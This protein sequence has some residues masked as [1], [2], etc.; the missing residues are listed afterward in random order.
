MNNM[1]LLL[2]I[3]LFLMTSIVAPVQAQNSAA[4]SSIASRKWLSSGGT[5]KIEQRVHD[6]GLGDIVQET[7]SF[8]G[9]SLPDVVVRHEYDE[10]RRSWLPVAASPGG[11]F[12]SGGTV[13][14]MAQSQ[15]SDTAPF[16][17]T[18]YDGFLQS[19]PAAQYKAGTQ[20]Q[21]NDRKVSVS[22]SEHVGAG[23]FSDADG[24]MYTL[25]G[26]KF[27]RTRVLDEDSCMSAEYT[28]LNGR[29]MA[30][31]TTQGMTFY[32][33]D[34]KGDIKYVIP[35]ILS[36][37][38]LSHYGDESEDIPDTDDMMRK[39]AYVYRYDSQ[40]HCIYKKLPGC[41]P[42]YY[43]YDR[44]GSCILSQDGKQRQKGV[45]AYSIPD[46]FG[47]PCISGICHNSASYSLEPLHSVSVHAEYD[48]SS[49]RTGGYA[50][51]N[52]TLVSDTL[53]YAAYYDGYSFIGH[54]GV[55]SSL[56]YA[57]VPGF[58]ADSSLGRGLQTGTATAILGG[59]SVT[60]YL[61]SAMY[62]DSRYNVAQVRATNHL[63]ST[64]ITSTSSSYTGKPLSVRI[65]NTAGP[66]MTEVC[67]T[68]AYDGADRMV[69]HTVSVTH[70]GPAASATLT[71]AY[72]AL[73]R[74]SS[75]TRPLATEQSHDI[76]YTYDLHGWTKS[77]A[78][79]G[80]CEELFYADGP[81]T[82]CYNG[83]VSSMR[84]SNSNYPYKRGYKLT[85][86]D[87]NRLIQAKYGRGDNIGGA[88]LFSENI[89][90]DAHGN[91]T[92]ITRLGKNASSSH[93]PMDKLTLS[94]DGN[95][96]AGVT[97]AAAD[98]DATGTFEYKRAKGSQYMYDEN[99]SLI[100]D[101]SRGIAYITYDV[102]GNPQRICFTNGNE[103]RYLYSATGEKLRTVYYV[104]KPN[105]T[106]TFGVEPGEPG[107][108]DI[109]YTSQMNYLLGGRLLVR[110]GMADR[111][112]FDGG[113]AKASILNPM[114]YNFTMHY[115]NTDHLGSNRE[116]VAA[117]GTVEQITNYYPFGAPFAD[118]ETV[119]DA[120]LQPYKYNGKELDRMHG[121][122]TYDYGARQYNPILTRWDRMDPLCEKYYDVSPYAYC[123]NNP[124]NAIDPDG[125]KVRYIN[126]ASNDFKRK[127]ANAIN[128]LNKH[129]V[130]YIF[131]KL[132]RLKTTI[133]IAQMPTEEL[134]K[135]TAPFFDSKSNTIY[136][137]TNMAVKTTNGTI[138]SPYTILN[139]E[140]DHA[141][142]SV[143][144]PKGHKKDKE[145]KDKKYGNIMEKKTIEGTEQITAR[146]LGEIKDGEVTRT[147][148]KGE[149][150]YGD[151]EEKE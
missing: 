64:D 41:E 79:N 42:V 100:A 125:R 61:Y 146:A 19:Q 104:A 99:G 130:G 137:D 54:H 105:I 39:F 25:P 121:L 132:E 55:P 111:I 45:W 71:Y 1:R 38:I 122:D 70:G 5:W 95:R 117:D 149:V 108:G 17:R 131:S 139:H 88:W 138:M 89:Q 116:V 24:Y 87:A 29:L 128:I 65:Q 49:D 10:Y 106:R 118:P 124:V 101:R 3:L 59:G 11:G 46:R 14:D 2:N 75:I 93:G 143:K 23:M 50:V 62:Y 69:S 142:D 77:I 83:N 56:A 109:L 47:R 43:V 115:F 86:D 76:T 144:N 98:Y 85:Y 57:A 6:N 30:S 112:Y 37:Y 80:F 148:H 113:Y 8:P 120:D 133:Y 84:W 102:T 90:Y 67:H 34:Q 58:T 129:G 21:G 48:G 81:G 63:G 114:T 135:G 119:V 82:P 36:A 78:T 73:G 94:Y 40:R 110:N 4:G 27:L 13:A 147:N 35:P 136:W 28:D 31:E 7:Q 107:Q 97:E 96:L 12:A 126:N 51:H 33:Y 16:S 20:W 44:T 53:Y 66:G 68:Y 72:D 18:V 127:F 32:I 74:L 15:Y 92:S 60:G 123:E 140:G 9:S 150:L 134:L 145:T 103:T 141:L 22:Y 52:L 151:F 91:A 26:V